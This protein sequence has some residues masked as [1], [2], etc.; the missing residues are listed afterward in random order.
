MRTRAATLALA[1]FLSLALLSCSSSD[2]V[3]PSGDE[4]LLIADYIFADPDKGDFSAIL[5]AIVQDPDSGVRRD[6][7][8]VIF[9]VTQ[10]GAIL[11]PTEIVTNDDGEAYT[12]VAA[13]DFINVEARSG[14]VTA[15]IAMD[16]QGAGISEN[17]KPTARIEVTTQNPIA[18]SP[19][20]FDVSDSTDFDGVIDTWKITDYGDGSAASAEFD[21][22]ETTTTTHTFATPDVYTVRVRV[23]DDEG[24]T[25]TATT[26]VSVQ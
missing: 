21:F 14:T 24:A 7:V 9:R 26:D 2:P 3:T 25:D 15:S 20:T 16:A 22:D 6:G 5:Q 8:V 23:T 4:I 17:R 1:A 19:V 10:G 12:F 18:G 13:Q 11:D